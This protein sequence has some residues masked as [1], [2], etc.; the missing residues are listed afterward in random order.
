MSSDFDF[1]NEFET[2]RQ[3]N[4]IEDNLKIVDKCNCD[5]S[6]D[7]W[8]QEDGFLVCPNCGYQ[9]Y[10]SLDMNAEYRFYGNEDSKSVDPTRC[11]MPIDPL[12]PNSSLSTMMS[13]KNSQLK[14]LQSWSSIPYKERSLKQVFDIITNTC[15]ELKLNQSVIQLSKSIYHSIRE[16]QLSRGRN[17]NALLSACIYNAC[18]ACGV[19]ILPD[20]IYK[21]FGLQFCDL[22]EGHKTLA[23]LLVHSKHKIE[24]K[25]SDWNDFLERFCIELQFN[26]EQTKEIMNLAKKINELSIL[27][28]HIPQSFAS[29]VLYYYIQQK[30]INHINKE[31]IIQICDIS[32]VTIEK[33]YKKILPWTCII[34]D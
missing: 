2:I 6:M 34:F 23:E 14:R 8:I 32:K 19:K 4:T 11:G 12:L 24:I 28:K 16:H 1:F 31:Q 18:K 5:I 27:K 15:N 9:I 33:I 20:S 13:G 25:P 10:S 26:N 30:N 7:E 21:H 3:S 17:R 22:C 29:G